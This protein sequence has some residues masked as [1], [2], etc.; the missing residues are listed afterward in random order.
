MQKRSFQVWVVFGFNCIKFSIILQETSNI[1]SFMIIPCTTIRDKPCNFFS[2]VFSV[3]EILFNS[4]HILII[5]NPLFIRCH[6]CGVLTICGSPIHSR[7]MSDRTW[8]KF[9]FWFLSA[10][11]LSILLIKLLCTSI[12]LFYPRFCELYLYGGDT[13]AYITSTTENLVWRYPIWSTYPCQ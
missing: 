10:D 1:E 7:N 12:D 2:F 11:M 5:V 4:F 13:P 3:V 8:A 9:D 6:N